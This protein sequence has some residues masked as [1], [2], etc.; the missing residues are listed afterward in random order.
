MPEPERFG[1][2]ALPAARRL[3]ATFAGLDVIAGRV[4][5]RAAVH[6]LPDVLKVIP[7]A[8]GRYHRH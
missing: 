4:L 1:A 7:L 5:G 6:L 3:S 8:Q 2:G